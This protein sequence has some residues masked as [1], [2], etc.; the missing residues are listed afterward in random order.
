MLG[1]PI[2]NHILEEEDCLSCPCSIMRL[3]LKTL[4]IDYIEVGEYV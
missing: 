4:Q 1:K 3:H 2:Y